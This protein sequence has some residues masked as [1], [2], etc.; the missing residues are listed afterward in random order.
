MLL[1]GNPEHVFIGVGIDSRTIGRRALFVALRGERFDGHDFL[2][3]AV[4]KGAAGL[5]VRQEDPA[6]QRLPGG[7]A[8]REI[9]VIAVP[10]TLRAL[11][12]LAAFHRRRM[13]I[14]VVAVTGTNGKTTTKEM[15][16]A[17]LAAGRR[18]YRSPGNLNNHIGVPLS[19]LGLPEESEAAV[20]EFG[21]GGAGEIRRL[22]EITQ[23]T[24][25]VITN[26]SEAHLTTL[27]S[28]DAVARAKGEI[29][30]R[31]PAAGWAVLNRDDR[32]VWALRKGVRA[33]VLSFGL[34]P[35][36]DVTADEIALGETGANTFR[37]LSG[38][39]SVRVRLQRPGRHEVLNALAAAAAAQVLSVPLSEMATGLAACQFPGM[40]WE[41]ETLPN[42]AHLINDAYNANPASVRAAIRTVEGL[43]SGRRN[44]AVLGDMLE[45]G[46]LSDRLH[47]EVGRAAAAGPF[48]LLVTVGTHSRW[49][50]A[51]AVA[52]GMDRAA[53]IHC[54]TWEQAAAELAGRVRK[55]D[56]ILLKASRGMGLERIADALRKRG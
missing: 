9:S 31:L 34:T 24:V 53:V 13:D 49:I 20:F 55:T 21:M 2:G 11:Q 47:Q 40:R 33:R 28:P 18:V 51:A 39:Q 35:G 8:A 46:E 50:A 41:M 43:G 6:A 38:G 25:A 7:K 4:K 14:P 19:L 23:P 36:C 29:L 52:G 1:K 17:V 26:V 42:G 48:S 32:R 54:D 15:L 16:Y 56:R 44:I 3:Q 30:E 12:D 45:L 22:A 37:L 10:D 27:K 5:V